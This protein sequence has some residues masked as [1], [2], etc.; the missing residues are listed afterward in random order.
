MVQLAY[1]FPIAP[2]P[3]SEISVNEMGEIFISGSRDYEY[4]DSLFF[5]VYA[6][7]YSANYELEWESNFGGK[8]QNDLHETSF[9]TV[10]GGMLVTGQF[11]DLKKA[12]AQ[13]L[14]VK[15]DCQGKLEWDYE[16]CILP[17]SPTMKLF[18]NPFS[19]Q[20]TIHLPDIGLEDKTEL[21]LFSMSGQLVYE[22]TNVGERVI[23]LS[24]LGLS[25]GMYILHVTINENQNLVE[26]V[27]CY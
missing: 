19:T 10:D 25:P 5:Q 9:R 15:V 8:N 16:S 6:A 23:Q 13:S 27:I 2:L 22:Q 12:K 20:L 11:L 14:I 26:K 18:P 24:E 7:K 21:K 17:E 3:A 4:T 1:S